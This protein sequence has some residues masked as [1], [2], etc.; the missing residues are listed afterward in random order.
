[1]LMISI[2]YSEINM[3]DTQRQSLLQ[4]NWAEAEVHCKRIWFVE[5]SLEFTEQQGRGLD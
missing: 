3:E 5:V 2:I 1:M 4:P